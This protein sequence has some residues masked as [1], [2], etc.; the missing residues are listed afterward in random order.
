MSRTLRRRRS[1]ILL[2]AVFLAGAL[3]EGAPLDEMHTRVAIALQDDPPLQT[4]QF[5]PAS[6]DRDVQSVPAKCVS[7]T[8]RDA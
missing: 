6:S 7:R 2:I 4:V 5:V 1:P 3:V 8:K